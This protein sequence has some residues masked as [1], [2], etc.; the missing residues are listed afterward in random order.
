MTAAP[1]LSIVVPAL[2]EAAAIAATLDALS[3]LRAAGHEVIVVDG[4]SADATVEL[5]AP[6]ADRV[7]AAARGRAA[8]MNAGAAIATGEALVFLHADTRLPPDAVE[9]IARA[10]AG[11]HGWGRFDVVLAGRS[12]WLP[13]VAAAM[14]L[15]SRLTGIATGD[16]GI[17][18]RRALFARAGGF[19]V[20]PLMEDIALSR[21]LKRAAGR[22]AALR[23]RVSTSGRRWD[24]RGALRTILLMWKLRLA[25]ALGADPAALA[26]GYAK[27]RRPRVLQ[28]FVRAPRKGTVK[29]RLAR[30]VGDVAALDA[31]RRLV[32]RALEVAADARRHGVVD[33]VELWCAPD[34]TDADCARWAG[35]VGA[36]LRGQAP[37]D[38]GARMRAA[39]EDALARGAVPILVGSDCPGLDAGYLARASDALESH[40]AVLGP[41]EDGGYVL[42][43]L[44]RPLPLFDGIAWSTPSVL[45]QTRAALASAG[46]RWRE[47][48]VLWDVDT[49]EDLARWHGERATAA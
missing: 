47:L 31:Y 15:R 48:P 14:N 46:A 3:P 35:R 12:R 45:A 4:G 21:T 11:G 26:Q 20:Q 7:L 28:L 5:A 1:R 16:Q 36:T 37:G 6:R 24:E 38:L 43:G 41:A 17:F 44:A 13:V 39:V 25:Y 49:A 40:D 2:D 29:T 34:A 19:P 32:A 22:P 10:L 42:V 27:P 18:V 30:A 23:Q 33:A 9:A 8:Q